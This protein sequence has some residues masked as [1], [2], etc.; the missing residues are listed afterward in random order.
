MRPLLF[1]NWSLINARFTALMWALAVIL[2]LV[3]LAHAIPAGHSSPSSA[4]LTPHPHALL[5]RSR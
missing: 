4:P 1:A 2:A 3:V 5:A